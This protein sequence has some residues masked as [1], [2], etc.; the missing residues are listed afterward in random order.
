[1]SGIYLHIP[2][3]KTRCHYC[4]FFSNT[5][6][7]YKTAFVES[8]CAELVREKN[9]LNGEEIHTI[10]FGG[11]T[12]SLLNADDF[13]MIF[14][15]LQRNYD[16]SHCEEITLEANPDDLSAE[17]L[18]VLRSYP[19]NR[20]SIGV[21]S[22]VDGE[23]QQINRRH[24][25]Q[26]AID[27]VQRCAKQF[28]NISVDLIYGYPSQTMDSFLYSLEKMA[29][30]P[31][32][33]ISA[34]HL[35]YEKGTVL[36]HKL[37]QGI[38]KEI[39]EETS[40][41]IYKTLVEKLAEKGFEQYEIS[42]F[43]QQG[44]ESKHNSAYWTGEKYLGVGTSAHSFNGVSRRWNVASL[45]QYISNESISETEILSA[46]DRYNEFILTSLRTV[47]GISLNKLKELHGEEMFVYCLRNA[48]KYMK[49]NILSIEN[50]YLHFTKNGFLISDV[51]MAELFL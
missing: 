25:A 8:L 46:T 4:D 16:L 35:T 50:N 5:K 21:Q 42:N 13:D 47:R 45:L 7:E 10:Y 39:D 51:V 49:D 14:N 1:M 27:A 38:I 20:I 18:A 32:Q 41:L 48:D 30:L 31:V 17:Y 43:A 22:L 33:H 23:L 40:I 2:F 44:F 12:P 28:T 19:F 26:Q 15:V 29:N 36:Q 37:Q 24:T 6:L 34:Y 11:G 3:C 9:Y